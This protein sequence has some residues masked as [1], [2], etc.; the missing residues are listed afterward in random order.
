MNQRYQVLLVRQVPSPAPDM[1]N[2][3]TEWY[4]VL[5]IIYYRTRHRGMLLSR[6]QFVEAYPSIKDY[7]DE[8]P[9]QT[10]VRHAE[11]CLIELLMKIGRRPAEIGVSKL[12]CRACYVWI[13]GVN[14][15]LREKGVADSWTVSGTH[16]KYYPCNDVQNLGES[17][18]KTTY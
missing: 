8:W 5:D 1:H 9:T 17:K 2:M 3:F 4:K 18:A 12:C 6:R 7:N 11:V 15:N 10:F 14:K 13:D 16:G